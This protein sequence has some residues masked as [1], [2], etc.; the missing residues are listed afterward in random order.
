MIEKEFIS[1]NL[2]LGVFC[3]VLIGLFVIKYV[4]NFL[5]GDSEK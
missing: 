5:G 4:R 1:M 3:G 2:I